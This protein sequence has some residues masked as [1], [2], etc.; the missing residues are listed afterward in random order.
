MNVVKKEETT[1]NVAHGLVQVAW[2][3][4]RLWIQAAK[5]D[6]WRNQAFEQRDAWVEKHP[7]AVSET[8]VYHPSYEGAVDEDDED[9]AAVAKP[10]IPKF[11]PPKKTAS[12]E[13]D[14]SEYVIIH[15]SDKSLM[16]PRTQ[17]DDWYER[18]SPEDKLDFLKENPEVE[19]K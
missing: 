6:E 12:G 3:G 4:K 2:S 18:K 5:L 11:K 14:Q 16:M 8:P 1:E 13:L 17:L 15:W 9:G 19:I 10:V 7:Y